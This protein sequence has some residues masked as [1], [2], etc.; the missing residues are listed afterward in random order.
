MISVKIDPDEKLVDAT[1]TGFVKTEEAARFSTEVKKAMRQFGPQEAALLID[2]IGFAPMTND[3]LALLRG[4]GRDVI[5]GFRKTALVQEFAA[6]IQNRKII[7][8]PP[9]VKIPSYPSREEALKY[10][11][12][13]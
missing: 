7:E 9:G 12:E 13:P 3:V 1:I 5:G 6:K 10:L 4:M 11:L 8:P 2:L